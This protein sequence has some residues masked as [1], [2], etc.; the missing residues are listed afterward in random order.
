MRNV[1]K[2][3][4]L[5]DRADFGT[6]DAGGGIKLTNAS[7]ILTIKYDLTNP[8]SETNLTMIRKRRVH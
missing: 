4:D 3:S 5:F 7:K 8:Q 6:I 2:N 1:N